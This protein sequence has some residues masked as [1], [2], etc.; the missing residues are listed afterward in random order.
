MSV[1]DRLIQWWRS[2]DRTPVVSSGAPTGPP[3]PRMKAE[4][5]VLVALDPDLKAIKQEMDRLA[6]EGRIP[7]TDDEKGDA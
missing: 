2:M 7:D 4:H 3:W 1:W 6:R 5:E